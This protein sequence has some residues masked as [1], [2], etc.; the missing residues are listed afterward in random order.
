[1]CTLTAGWECV[2]ASRP[3]RSPL[4]PSL[5]PYFLFQLLC[6]VVLPRESLLNGGGGC[7]GRPVWGGGSDPPTTR[8]CT[9][10]TSVGRRQILNSKRGDSK[11][12]ETRWGT[13]YMGSPCIPR[14]HPTS[15]PPAQQTMLSN[16]HS[17]SDAIFLGYAVG[18]TSVERI[19]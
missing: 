8:H 13:G 19:V 7:T 1:M 12:N 17:W 5:C 15:P 9:R 2:A 3:G 16:D 10:R 18:S 6:P 11:R 4:P 14:V